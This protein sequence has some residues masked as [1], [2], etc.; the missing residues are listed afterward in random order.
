MRILE[1]QR[2]HL[3]SIVRRAT[4][5]TGAAVTA[6]AS[7]PRPAVII[8]DD[9][10]LAFLARTG[11]TNAVN[12]A[13]QATAAAAAV[14][15]V[16]LQ[17]SAAAT[18]ILQAAG[19][20][21]GAVNLALRPKTATGLVSIQTSGGA[22]VLSGGDGTAT[23]IAATGTLTLTATVADVDINA[24]TDVTI[25]TATGGVSID[26]A[27]ASNFSTSLGD[28]TLSAAAVATLTSTGNKVTISSPTSSVAITGNTT[29]SLTAATGQASLEAVAADV[30]ITG[31]TTASM[32]ATTGQASLVATAA[33]VA[34]GGKTGVTIQ[35][36]DSAVPEIAITGTGLALAGISSLSTVAGAGNL[37]IGRAEV[38]LLATTVVVLLAT[39]AATDIVVA[40]PMGPTAAVAPAA[41][42]AYWV[43]IQPGVSFTIN[44]TQAPAVACTFN[45]VVIHKGA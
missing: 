39:M 22:T 32:T 15:W 37:E 26:A 5:P 13:F 33:N 6:D 17:S 9:R 35:D 42:D 30:A 20:G 31:N 2:N 10:T 45:Y 24:S 4:Q 44:M 28:L 40:S 43:T 3:L 23:F 11:T 8:G 14:S 12:K 36:T 25:D 18:P 27:A 34:I 19:D 7:I 1:R 21:A 38:P 16:E 29:A 41:G